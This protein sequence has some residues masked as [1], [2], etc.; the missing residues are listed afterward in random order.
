MGFA[1]AGAVAQ[2]GG[3]EVAVEGGAFDAENVGDLLGGVVSLVVEAL[4]LFGLGRAGA[5]CRYNRQRI[6]N[7]QRSYMLLKGTV[8]TPNSR[9]LITRGRQ[10]YLY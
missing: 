3:V 8:L 4:G 10:F 1:G 2:G 6:E 7:T 5:F 9:Q